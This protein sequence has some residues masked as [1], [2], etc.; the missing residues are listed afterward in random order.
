MNPCVNMWL[1]QL[2]HDFCAQNGDGICVEE[3]INMVYFIVLDQII[4]CKLQI[5]FMIFAKRSKCKN[6][7]MFS[8]LNVRTT[9]I[10]VQMKIQMGKQ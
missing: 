3:Q 9:F 7:K 8:A 10:I 2:Q 4:F 1:E 5:D 6:S